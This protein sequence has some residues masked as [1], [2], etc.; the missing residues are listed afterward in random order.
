MANGHFS[1]PFLDSFA[2]GFSGEVIHTHN[3]RTPEQYK[4]KNIVVVVKGKI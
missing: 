3:Y 1:K 4:D 2:E